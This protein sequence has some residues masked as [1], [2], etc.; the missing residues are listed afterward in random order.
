MHSI[1][2]AGPWQLTPLAHTCWS[3]EGESIEQPGELPPGGKS[4]VPSDWGELLGEEFR[5]RVQLE[6]FFHKPTGLE[7]GDRVEIALSGV[8]A[9]GTISLNGQPLGEIPPGGEP[10]RFD[11]G[12]LLE[13][14][15]CLVVKVEL[16]RLTSNSAPLLRP[17]DH[18]EAGGI[19]G[20]VRLEITTP[21]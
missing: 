13:H 10:A 11:I 17:A 4:T 18:G 14:R 2:L 20:E 19:L 21:G 3:A 6:R 16:P 15:N 5:G 9:L 12:S 7:P 8:D 1:R